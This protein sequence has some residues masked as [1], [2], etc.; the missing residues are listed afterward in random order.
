MLYTHALGPLLRRRDGARA[1][2]RS[3]GRATIGAG[4]CATRSSLTSAPGS[5][6]CPGFRTSS[7]RPPTPGAPW[8]PPIR[9]RRS[10]PAVAGPARR[11]PHHG[12]AAGRDHHRARPVLHQARPRHPRGNRHVVA[13][14]AA[15]R[16]A[17]RGLA[18]L[19]DHAGIRR[20]VL[21]A[22]PRVDPAAR[23]VG[24]RPRRASSGWSRSC[25]RV[26]FVVH[27]SSYAP[28]FKSDMRD[29]GG[30]MKPLIHQNDGRVRRP[31][32]LD[33]AGLV[34]PAGGAALR[35]TSIGPV[36]DPSYMDWVYALKRLANANPAATLDPLVASLKP[37]QRLLYVRPLTEGVQDWKAPWVRAGPAA[38][39]A[40]GADPPG[41]RQQRSAQTDSHRAAQLP[42]R[43]HPCLQRRAV[44][45]GFLRSRDDRSEFQPPRRRLSPR[46]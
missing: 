36:D 40:V 4:S 13:H 46:L 16:H 29:I 2:P 41:R 25:C 15:V 9:V 31:A 17:D 12:G 44:R 39:G 3:G 30:E 22:D 37:G 34:L 18:G 19:A 23:G 5:C 32:R 20:P 33:P 26:V 10:G 35:Q 6:S 8:A 45:E 43:Q 38:R 1:D 27:P 14:L 11:R 21:G 7:T 24:R 42:R 28:Q